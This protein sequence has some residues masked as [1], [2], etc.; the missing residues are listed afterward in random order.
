MRAKQA[1]FEQAG[2][3]EVIEWCEVDLPAPG[4]GEVLL[5]HEA[6][7]LNFIDTYHRSGLYPVTFPAALGLEA[8]GVVEAVGDGVTQL[9]PG[10]RGVTMGPTRGAYATAQ[11]VPAGELFKLAA[12][13]DTRTAAAA[14][15]KG[16]TTEMLAD[17]V[18]NPQAGDWALVHAAAGGVGQMLV[19]WLTAKGVRVIGTAGSADK[20]ALAS[21]LGCELVIP[22]DA[23][24]IG[25]QARAATSGK[26]VRVTYDGVGKATWDASLKA[27][28][29]RGIIASFGNASGAVTGV[30]LGVLAAGGSL[31][32]TRPTL[33]DWYAT[34]EE[35]AAGAARLWEMIRSGK[36]KV[37][38]G[39]TYPLDQAAQA[40]HDL[41]ARLTTGSTLLLP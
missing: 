21:A 14:L 18:A 23:P 38:I 31:Y 19:Q 6:V 34:P 26:G 41:E 37:E 30:N 5:R 27:T 3:P 12:A 24:D 17:R 7:G 4:P 2:G 20:Q 36:L 35:S 22:A 10:E 16:C 11:V 9:K 1:Y 13:V 40:H 33:F 15:L 25:E 32:V 29:R 39:Q 8:A 28:E